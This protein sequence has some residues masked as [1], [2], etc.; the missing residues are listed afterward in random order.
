MLYRSA[1]PCIFG[2][3]WWRSL[4]LP[5]AAQQFT[6][7]AVAHHVTFVALPEMVL[8]GVDGPNVVDAVSDTVTVP[9]NQ[10]LLVARPAVRRHRV[11]AQ[12]R[13]Q[14]GNREQ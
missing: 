6:E 11:D 8:Q 14:Q 12:M 4:E 13:K 1:A 10:N 7:V 9:V 2:A 3:T 5:G